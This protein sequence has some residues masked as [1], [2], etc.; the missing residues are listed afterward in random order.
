MGLVDKGYL[1]FGIVA[2]AVA[3]ILFFESRQPVTHKEPALTVI[4][5]SEADLS[6]IQNDIQAVNA[7]S[8]LQHPATPSVSAMGTGD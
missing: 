7:L 5:S 3:M 4:P 8:N 6:S 2:L 1:I